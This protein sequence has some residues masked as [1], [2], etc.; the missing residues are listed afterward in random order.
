M[1][2]QEVQTSFE[3]WKVPCPSGHG[4]SVS[5]ML[6]ESI[7]TSSRSRW[8]AAGTGLIDDEITEGERTSEDG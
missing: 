5:L 1:C 7:C 8:L 3:A 6:G 2:G 4:M